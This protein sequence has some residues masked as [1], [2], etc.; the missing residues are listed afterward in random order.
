MEI[1]VVAAGAQRL[2]A[3]L[4]AGAAR[5]GEAVALTTCRRTE[6]Y[7]AADDVEPV[8]E[9]VRRGL[10][11]ARVEVGADAA[12]HLFR[13]AAGLQSPVLGEGEVLRQL[14]EAWDEA[15]GEGR[16]AL[17]LNRLFADAVHV[18]KRVR[19]ETGIA[20]SGA[21][22]AGAVVAAI[23]AERI[24]LRGAAVL[25]VGA[26]AL[27]TSVALP[28]AGRGARIAVASRTVERAARLAE[29]CAG[30][31]LPLGQ[32]PAAVADADVVVA[33]IRCD[34]PVVTRAMLDA[35]PR[36]PLV[37]DLG[38]PPNV[39]ASD[40]CRRLDLDGLA[41]LAD[42]RDARRHS[43]V[44]AAEAIVDEELERFREW[45]SCRTV[46][47]ELTLLRRRGE[48]VVEAELRRDAGRLARLDDGDRRAVEALVHRV[49]S[50]LL[51]LP[52]VR[53]KQEAAAGGGE[54]ELYAHAIRRLFAE[55]AAA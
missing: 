12:R 5:S 21:S 19:A 50:S 27:A 54:A 53:L 47:P 45:R 17:L 10:A 36:A 42:A 46:V 33:A 15:R 31:A 16:T 48:A 43:A 13:V 52:T 6:L 8:A 25:V 51:H 40:S 49:A 38:F 28:L 3:E 23:E 2:P 7:L 26:G 55:D 9:R 1:A 37:V 34:R 29:A 11:G 30:R 41:G 14:R 35:A 18:G 39:E 32:L 22:Y 4:V 24:E 44:G 20:R